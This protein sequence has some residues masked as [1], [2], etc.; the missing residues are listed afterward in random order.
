MGAWVGWGWLAGWLASWLLGGPAGWLAGLLVCWLAQQSDRFRYT[1]LMNI[2]NADARPPHLVFVVRLGSSG[3]ML[4]FL[5]FLCSVIAASLSL[6]L[7]VP[8]GFVT[9]C[10]R[11]R[12]ALFFCALCS[13]CCCCCCFALWDRFMSLGLASA[14]LEK[15]QQS[16]PFFCLKVERRKVILGHF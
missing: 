8:L 2:E 15:D 7:L 6:A 5:Q 10:L 14:A 1:Y 16:F 9:E 13:C 4:C 3:E 12:I 11:A